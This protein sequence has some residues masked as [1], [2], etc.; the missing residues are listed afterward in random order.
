[1]ARKSLIL[2]LVLVC[3]LAVS[4]KPSEPT[5][6]EL[7]ASVLNTLDRTDQLYTFMKVGASPDDLAFIENLRIQS[8]NRPLAKARAKGDL[9]M[10]AG[11]PKPFKA[12]DLKTGKFS[13]GGHEIVLNFDKGVRSNYLALEKLIRPRRSALANWILPQA[14]AGIDWGSVLSGVLMGGGAAA[15]FGSNSPTTSTLGGV[16]ALA[17][18]GLLAAKGGL[19]SSHKKHKTTKV[20]CIIGANGV[21]ETIIRDSKGNVIRQITG[22]AMPYTV[23]PVSNFAPTYTQVAASSVTGLCNDPVALSTVNQAL[24]PT[25]LPAAGVVA[26]APAA[27]LPAPVTSLPAALPAT[28]AH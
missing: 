22:Y 25:V 23:A 9:L 15:F 14:D 10:I 18:V 13:Y 7:A 3:S 5:P 20:T 17:G 6:M 1:M 28:T 26:P 8:K 27:P 4:A 12:E 19:F 2:G 16:A 11:L 24:T 21:R